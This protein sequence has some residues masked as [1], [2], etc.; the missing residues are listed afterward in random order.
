[1]I[2]TW[3]AA[4]EAT[5]T[6]SLRIGLI[7]N[8]IRDVTFGIRER[9]E[10]EHEWGPGSDI[11]DGSHIMGGTSI[12]DTGDATAMAAL[13]GMQQGALFLLN[14]G[15]DLQLMIYLSG[16]WTALSTVDHDQLTGTTDD[17]HPQYVLK[18]GGVMTGNLD[19]SGSMVIAPAATETCG[20]L[21]LRY[22]ATQAHPTLG[23]LDA[24]VAN[25]I[26]ATAIATTT[27]I[28]THVLNAPG[29][30]ITWEVQPREFFPAIYQLSAAQNIHICG[31][32]TA[33]QLGLL[34]VSG[35]G[36]CTVKVYREWIT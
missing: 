35:A 21:L 34:Y 17:D 11:N 30:R 24:V 16:T 32:N 20:G 1:M 10:V 28:D 5:P 14:T 13:T 8:V 15:T 7:D 12:L 9:M 3:D 25:T 23:N 18:D 2:I 4:Y 19:M 29:D 33:T 36:A 22:H 6:S 26:P 31:G 27:Q